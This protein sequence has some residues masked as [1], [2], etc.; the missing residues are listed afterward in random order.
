M[1]LCPAAVV[2]GARSY[3]ALVCRSS[4]GS[5]VDVA[6]TRMQAICP[7][8]CFRRASHRLTPRHMQWRCERV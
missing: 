8:L 1:A 7:A 4:V 5:S 3:V 6:L 2:Y